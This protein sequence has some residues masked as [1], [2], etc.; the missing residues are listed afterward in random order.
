MGCDSLK[1]S[2]EIKLR[3]QYLLDPAILGERN[4]KVSKEAGVHWIDSEEVESIGIRERSH[5]QD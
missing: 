2:R 1:F 5:F 3:I 4:L